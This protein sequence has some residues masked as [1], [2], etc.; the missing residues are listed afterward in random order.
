MV[1]VKALIAEQKRL[2]SQVICHD[3]LGFN[4]PRLIAGADVGFEADGTVTRAAIALLSYPALELIDHVVARIPT[5][6]PYIPGV[7]SFRE[8]PALLAAWQQLK[9]QPQ[10]VLVDGQGLAHPRRFGVACHFGITIDRPT[11]GV[12]KSRLCGHYQPLATS[13]GAVEPLMDKQQ[14]IGQVWRSKL[15]C[16]PLF[17][18]VG[19]RISQPTALAWVK[20]CTKGYRLP[21]PIRWADAIASSRPAFV[22]WQQII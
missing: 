22:R 21:E 5:V 18:S 6:M 14:L 8:V 13:V 19:H 20:R 12:A 3:E 16:N 10:L 11:I 7:L 15:R 17:I 1:D 9:Q 2:V 4:E